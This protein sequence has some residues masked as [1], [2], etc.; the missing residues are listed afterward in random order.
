MFPVFFRF[1]PVTYSQKGFCVTYETS[2]VESGLGD[3][4]DPEEYIQLDVRSWRHIDVEE[5]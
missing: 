1:P 3:E 2:L 4:R 5:K